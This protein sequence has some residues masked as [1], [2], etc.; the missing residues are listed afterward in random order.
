MSTR[1]VITDTVNGSSIRLPFSERAAE[2][3]R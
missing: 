2:G 1:A 3:A